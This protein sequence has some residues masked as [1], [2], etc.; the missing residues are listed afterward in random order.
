MFDEPQV[1][2]LVLGQNTTWSILQ[3]MS[4]KRISRMF[5]CAYGRRLDKKI[6]NPTDVQYGLENQ[7]KNDRVIRFLYHCVCEKSNGKLQT[8]V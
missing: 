3:L 2:I 4:K 5:I 8:P 1:V 6:M 7:K